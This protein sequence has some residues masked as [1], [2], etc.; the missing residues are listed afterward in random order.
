M[1]KIRTVGTGETLGYFH[2]V[3]EN[4]TVDW[5]SPLIATAYRDR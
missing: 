1:G 3:Y 5:F 2:S 4:R